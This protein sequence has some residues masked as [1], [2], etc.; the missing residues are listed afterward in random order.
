MEKNLKSRATINRM[1]QKGL[2]LFYQKGFYNTSLDDILKALE[3]SKGAFY[4]HFQSKEDFMVSIVQ[5]LLFR[6]VYSTLIEPIEGKENP[7]L[8]IELC[9]ENALE[10]AEHNPLD[11]GFVL[12]NFMT[13]FNGRNEK[14]SRYLSDIAKVWEVSLVTAL[15]KGKSDG[16]LERHHDSEGIATYIM[17]SYIGVRSLMVSGNPRML[18]YQYMQQLRSYFK[19]MSLKSAF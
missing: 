12:A 11:F 16:F 15:Q 14:I 9:L 10:T 13:E 18:R 6:K 1:Q 17:A 19:G 8:N 2:E 7:F 3:L 4:H 5:H